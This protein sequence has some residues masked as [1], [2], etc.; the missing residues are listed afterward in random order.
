MMK[1][2]KYKRRRKGKTDYQAR[3]R[4]LRSGIPRVIIRKTNRYIVIQLVESKE[5]QDFVLLNVTSK[6]L[7]KNGWPEAA[8][9][10]LKSLPAAYLTGILFA[11]KSKGTK[12]ALVDMGIQRSTKGNR[13]Y[14]AIK[15]LVDGGME[16]TCD[17]K[18]FPSNA[19]INKAHVDT[20]KKNIQG[21]K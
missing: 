13:I 17:E 16:I 18:M 8:Q 2:V 12:K 6:E 21:K 3:L 19:M 9:G 10:S 11:K 14:A 1:K 15:G 5:A 7:L 20:I 4:L